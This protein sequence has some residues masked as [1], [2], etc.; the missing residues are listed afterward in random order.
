VQLLSPQEWAELSPAE[1]QAIQKAENEAA[2]DEESLLDYIPRITPRFMRPMHL[3]P[4]AK[5]IER[6]R[7]GERVRALISAPPRHAKTELLLHGIPYYLAANPTDSVAYVSYGAQFAHGKSRFARGYAETAGFNFH[8]EF[9][10]VAEWRNTEGGG[11]VATGI[12]GPLT[13]KGFQLLLLDDPH[14]DRIEAESPRA[15]DVV[16]QWFRGTATTRVEPGGSILVF[17]QRWHDDDLV[18]RL[19]RDADSEYEYIALE[20]ID[21]AETTPLW[22]ERWTIDDLAKLRAEVGDYNWWS[23]YKSKPRPR[24]GK[25]FARDPAR[26]VEPDLSGARIILSVDAAGTEGTKSD[27]TVGGALAFRGVGTEMVCDILDLWRDKKTPETAAPMLFEFQ[28]RV[29]KGVPFYIEATAHGKQLHK[30]LKAIE[31]GLRITEIPPIGDKF[32]RAQPVA[33]AWNQGRVRIPMHAP[34]VP[35]FITEFE[36]FTGLADR[37]DDQVDMLSLG[38]NAAA[39]NGPPVTG[40]VRLRETKPAGVFG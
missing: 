3:A 30:A 12:D 29:A 21:D 33:A 37:H 38:W 13:G 39:A 7:R 2:I 28:Q 5:L 26:Y 17:M 8:P 1:L 6:A 23:Q 18:G 4:V 15:R 27:Y 14:K 10:T 34:W 22:P 40:S 31:P 25:V 19:L 11:C 9:N 36:K 24:G 32:V 35:E 20:A 16:E